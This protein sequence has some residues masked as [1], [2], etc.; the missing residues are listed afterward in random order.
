VSADNG[1]FVAYRVTASGPGGTTSATSSARTVTTA[2]SVTGV[3]FNRVDIN[4][5][6][7]AVTWGSGSTPSPTMTV[8]LSGAQ[9][10]KEGNTSTSTQ[11][12]TLSGAQSVAEGN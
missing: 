7:S 1:T 3:L 10:I 12:V 5:A 8:V 4:F 2:P 11:T 6:M 9:S